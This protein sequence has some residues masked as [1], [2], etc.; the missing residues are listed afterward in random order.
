MGFVE[1]VQEVFRKC[2]VFKGRSTRSEYWYWFLFI[3]ICTIALIILEG[4]IWGTAT[5]KNP[6]GSAVISL[7]PNND[8]LQIIFG[9]CML[10]PNM[11]VT[12]RRLHDTDNSGW[13]YLLTF[14]FIGVIPLYIM[15]AIEGTKGANR[16]GEN[17][18]GD[19]WKAP[20]HPLDENMQDSLS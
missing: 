15:C 11:A 10:L 8:M 2:L 17:P 12:I 9:I 20:M 6:D 1:A 7:H 18:L 16:F 4:F 3:G 14:T 13:W 5:H 19:D